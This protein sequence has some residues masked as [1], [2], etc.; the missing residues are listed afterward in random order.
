MDKR[1]ECVRRLQPE[2]ARRRAE[3][4][5]LGVRLGWHEKDVRAFSE[6][7]S[8]CAWRCC[9]CSQLDAVIR[10]Q[11][12]L[13]RAIAAKAAR[14]EARKASGEPDAPTS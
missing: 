10:E 4:M 9:S 1:P 12:A 14:R 7:L 5:R 6:G 11:E 8:G 3:V 13:L 2:R